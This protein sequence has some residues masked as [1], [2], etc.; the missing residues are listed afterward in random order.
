MKPLEDTR[1]ACSDQPEQKEKRWDDFSL[2]NAL[3]TRDEKIQG[4]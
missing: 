1:A 3:E 2:T 4:Q